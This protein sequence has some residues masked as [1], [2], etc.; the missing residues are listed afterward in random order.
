MPFDQPLRQYIGN[1]RTPNSDDDAA[2]KFKKE[3]TWISHRG[4]TTCGC[5]PLATETEPENRQNQ[6]KTRQI[7]AQHSQQYIRQGHAVGH[8]HWRRPKALAIVVFESCPGGG[9]EMT[10]LADPTWSES[11]ANHQQQVSVSTERNYADKFSI[12]VENCFK[13]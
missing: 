11:M 13:N 9:S 10:L 1:V 3:I 4:P 2:E 5:F 8:A 7:P 12:S 6:N